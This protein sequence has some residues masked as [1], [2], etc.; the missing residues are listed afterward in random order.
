[1][2]QADKLSFRASS[3]PRSP[4]IG[5]SILSADFAY[6]ADDA[7]AALEAGSDFLHVDVMDGSFVPNLTMGPALLKCVRRA[8]PD[9]FLDV[10]LMVDDPAMFVESFA[11][12]GADNLTFHIEAE[13]DPRSVIETIHAAGCSAGLAINPPTD[14][15]AIVPFVELADVILV[16]SVNPGFSGQAFIADVL[17]KVATIASQLRD[18]QRLEMDGGI[19]PSTAPQCI[20][21]GCDVLAVASAIFGSNDYAQAVAALRSRPAYH[22]VDSP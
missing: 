3:L 8:L 19:N 15:A 4:L 14:V 1:M 17:K 10:H 9:A 6:L 18:D 5:A 22:K 16:M 21:A 20:S 13:P 12:A 7:L 11:D 2:A